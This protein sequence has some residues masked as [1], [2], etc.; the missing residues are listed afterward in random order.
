MAR[1][2]REKSQSGMYTVILRTRHMCFNGKD[3]KDIFFVS[4]NNAKQKDN[5]LLLAY[6]VGSKD[7]YMVVK[8]G[9]LGLSEFVKRLC[10]S[11]SKKYKQTH[12]NVNNVFYDRYLSEP[13]NDEKEMLKAVVKINELKYKNGPKGESL[14]FVTS[15]DN[16]FN[17]S[18]INSDYVLN[19]VDREKFFKMHNDCGGTRKFMVMEKL[20]DKQVADYIYYTYNIKAS[21]INKINK[22]LLNEILNNVVKI[23][24]ASARQIGRVTKISL[25][26]LW[27]L[28][29]KK[30]TTEVVKEVKWK[31]VL[32]RDF[33]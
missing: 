33:G 6:G 31:K 8:E 22:P 30:D 15:L 2:K 16:Y 19:F 24:K 32:E 29:K 21:E 20:S 4:L 18:L 28:F 17:D 10:L 3:L 11:F 9:E 13:I 7:A 25:R 5:T 12:K 1:Q 26:Y 23:T 27:G 14:N